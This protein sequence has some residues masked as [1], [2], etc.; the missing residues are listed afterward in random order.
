MNN[1]NYINFLAAAVAAPPAKRPNKDP[2]PQHRPSPEQYAA[3][4]AAAQATGQPL[5]RHI[6]HVSYQDVLNMLKFRNSH[7]SLYQCAGQIK[8]F[9]FE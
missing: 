3:M 4:L 5:P 7:F 2:M 9:Y 8:Y 1:T 6:H